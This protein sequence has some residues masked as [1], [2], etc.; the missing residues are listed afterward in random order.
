LDLPFCCD[1][2][3]SCETFDED[4]CPE[5]FM[6]SESKSHELCKMT[7]CHEDDHDICCEKKQK[8][9]QFD[10]ELC[11]QDSYVRTDAAKV[12]CTK[13]LCSDE[14]I[15]LCCVGVSQQTCAWFPPDYCPEDKV[16]MQ[17][18]AFK[19]YC[20]D[21]ACSE[22]DAGTCCVDAAKC[23]TYECPHGL[24]K[25][26][27][28]AN[29]PC[30]SD[31]CDESDMGTCCVV[32]ASCT[33][34]T[35]HAHS[36]LSPDA[37]QKWCATDPCGDDDEETCCVK[38]GN[39]DDFQDACPDGQSLVYRA[40]EVLCRQAACSHDADMENCCTN[41]DSCANFP[42]Q[43]PD[44]SELWEDGLC[45]HESCSTSVTD[46]GLCCQPSLGQVLEGLIVMENC[47]YDKIV[48]TKS[49]GKVEQIVIEAIAKHVGVKKD[50]VEVAI[51]A[52]LTGE[53]SID[54]MVDTADLDE[55]KHAVLKEK[56]EN[57]VS[58]ITTIDRKIRDLKEL[59]KDSA[60]H[61]KVSFILVADAMIDASHG[62]VYVR[63]KAV[64][65]DGDSW[66]VMLPG[67][68][69]EDGYSEVHLQ[70]VDDGNSNYIA[71]NV[72]VD[73]LTRLFRA[74]ELIEQG[75]LDPDLKDWLPL[76]DVVAQAD[77]E[78]APWKD[79]HGQLSILSIFLIVLAFAALLGGVVVVLYLRKKSTDDE[80]RQP[81][82]S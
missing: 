24:Q 20:A 70:S 78:N 61:I 54:F 56:F 74:S 68:F 27:G 49:R 60:E 10:W 29:T 57:K 1:D 16:V 23:S 14:D 80:A 81:L 3:V 77:A 11:P 59:K 7:V 2:R 58:L 71:A 8:C 38:Q 43:C 47:V 28:S 22:S 44:G 5:G 42:G 25:K 37:A 13:V 73:A 62:G 40:E 63:G 67:G 69:I 31:V 15:P 18:D 41:R 21:G 4:W 65:W 53:A 30:R 75:S 55:A 46:K 34:M 32:G 36:V 39:C 17:V 82:T 33:N 76:P 6:V 64:S 50:L 9:D 79:N 48:E 72:Y 45:E 66:S 51:S 52:S 26:T 35:C 19:S 12:P